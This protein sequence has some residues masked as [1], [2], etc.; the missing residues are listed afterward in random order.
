MIYKNIY[1]GIFLERTNRFIAKVNINNK[2]ETVHVKNTGRCKEILIPDTKVYLEKSDNPNRKTK[3]SLISVY[4]KDVLINI[5]SQVPNQVVFEALK[6]NEIESIKDVVYAKREKTYGNS[7]FDIY[8][9]T[10]TESGFIEVKG[11]TLEENKIAKFPDA[12]TIRG[13]KHI[14]ELIKATKEGYKCYILF[15]IQLKGCKMFISNK[16]M[17]P[18]FAR[19]LK[20]A[21]SKKVNILC[22]DS[23]VTKDKI[24]MNKKID[25]KV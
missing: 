16:E 3:Y 7:R 23:I 22:Y 15:L 6:N 17:D 21:K 13:T 5:D 20:K 25:I 2:I 18:I 10:K 11:V 4:K 8:Y 1:E 9:E 14:N 12:P 24:I 19:T